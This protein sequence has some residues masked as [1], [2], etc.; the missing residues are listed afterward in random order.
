MSHR[1]LWRSSFLITLKT[2][3]ARHNLNS[4]PSQCSGDD[5]F[6]IDNVLPLKNARIA[7]I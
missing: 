3:K 1:Y 7:P 2:N 6:A 4:M 5:K